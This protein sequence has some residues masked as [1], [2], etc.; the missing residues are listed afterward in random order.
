MSETIL[1]AFGAASVIW[2][3]G[4]GLGLAYG[5]IRRIRDVV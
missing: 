2:V 1:A 4:F 5:F 3:T